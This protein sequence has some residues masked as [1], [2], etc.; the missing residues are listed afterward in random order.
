MTIGSRVLVTGGAGFIGTALA[1]RYAD[2][3]QAWVAYDSLLPQVHGADPELTLPAT[4]DLVVGDVR[5]QTALSTTI[6]E[7][8]PTLV[9]HLAAETGT[10]QSL[11]EPTRHTDVNVTGTAVLLQALSAHLPERVVL[12]SSRAVY[13]EGE[14]LDAAGRVSHPGPRSAQ[15]LAAGQWDFPGLT[16]TPSR[17]GAT[18]PSPVNVYGATKLA[19]EHLLTA[20][21]AARSVRTSIARLQ[22]VYGPGQSPINPY[23]GITT[24]FIQLAQAGSVIPVYE[25]GHIT[26]DFVFIDDVVRALG[27]VA[28]AEGDVLVDVGSGVSTTIA[29]MAAV[30]A[31]LF[32]APEPQVTGQYRLGDVRSAACDMSDSRWALQGAAPVDLEQGLRRLA[33]W[34]REVPPA[35]A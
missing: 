23:T 2:A 17:A 4:A 5:D 33:E 10:G 3:C 13:G 19:Q 20:W 31:R 34:I 7:L 12:T 28:G 25:D 18:C 26:R 14:W 11:D 27:A 21:A 15:M 35:S 22:N 16:A 1:S 30:C 32:D 8:Q 9:V 24:L 29:E 6:A